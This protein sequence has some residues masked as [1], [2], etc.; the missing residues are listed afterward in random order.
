[1]APPLIQLASSLLKPF[2]PGMMKRLLEAW[3]GM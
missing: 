2:T 1:V 3:S